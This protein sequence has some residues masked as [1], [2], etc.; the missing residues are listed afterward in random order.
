MRH[1]TE[2]VLAKAVH[3]MHQPKLFKQPKFFFVF[4]CVNAMA[5]GM[6]WHNHTINIESHGH[7]RVTEHGV[8][9]GLKPRTQAYQQSLASK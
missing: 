1:L 5:F 6:L 7:N 4:W 3:G 8:K 2:E 9:T